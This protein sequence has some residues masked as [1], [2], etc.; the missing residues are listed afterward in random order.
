LYN[1]DRI[2][3]CVDENASSKEDTDTTDYELTDAEI[4]QT[5]DWDKEEEVPAVGFHAMILEMA[6]EIVN[7]SAC[8]QSRD[9]WNPSEIGLNC[10]RES[11]ANGPMPIRIQRIGPA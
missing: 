6:A 5:Q 10:G 3:A 7:T 8:A 2:L 11:L 9:T 4:R 1:L